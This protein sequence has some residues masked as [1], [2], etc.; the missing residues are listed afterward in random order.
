MLFVYWLPVVVLVL[1][2]LLTVVYFVSNPLQLPF[3]FVQI[4][5]LI[6][7]SIYGFMYLKLY[8]DN[9]PIALL[10][11][12]TVLHFL[13][14]YLLRK[15]IVVMPFVPILIIDICFLTVKGLKAVSFPFEIEGEEEDDIY[16][17][18]LEET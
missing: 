10:I 14:I 2:F 17:E 11:I 9:D 16:L 7:L 4:I 3:R 15:T 6:V 13:L 1:R 12:P 8:M 5:P 18:D